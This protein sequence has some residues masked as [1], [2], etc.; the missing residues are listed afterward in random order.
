MGILNNKGK[1]AFYSKYGS[2]HFW[3]VKCNKF[4]AYNI[5]NYFE[6]VV[7][8]EFFPLGNRGNNR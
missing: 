5:W 2:L 7:L 8:L 1:Q 3:C 4:Y 6:I